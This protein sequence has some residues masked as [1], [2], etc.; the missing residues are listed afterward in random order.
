MI[1]QTQDKELTRAVNNLN[2]AIG[3]AV[4]SVMEAVQNLTVQVAQT[5]NL[6][7]ELNKSIDETNR[8]LQDIRQKG[9]PT[10]KKV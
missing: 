3:G 2:G 8:N 5:N 10:W 6:L 1:I 9:L 4:W 7:Q